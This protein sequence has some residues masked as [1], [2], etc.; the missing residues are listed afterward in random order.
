MRHPVPNRTILIRSPDGRDVLRIAALRRDSGYPSLEVRVE[1][2]AKGFSGG[3]EL[4]L[5]GFALKEFATA[6]RV[7]ER[8]RQGR[9]ELHGMNPDELRL[10]VRSTDP[11]G[12][13]LVEFSISRRALVGERPEA[14]AIQVTGAFEVD[15]GTLGEI[16]DGF[17]QLV[18][19]VAA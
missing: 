8:S 15:P 5:D 19:A 10:V 3:S 14:V 17:G 6:L 7:F 11:A 18:K 13:L 4:W 1:G 9:V 16:L 12:H 2:T